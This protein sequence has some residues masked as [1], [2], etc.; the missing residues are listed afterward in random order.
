[1]HNILAKQQY[2]FKKGETFS[3]KNRLK[4]LKLLQKNIKNKDKKIA[5]ALYKDL[6]KS[7]NE[8][9]MCEIGLTINEISYFLKNLK[10]FT[11]DKI[12]PTPITNFYSKSII[13]SVPW[14]NV[15]IISPWNYPFLLS[16][17]PLIDAIAAGN[18]VI[19]KPSAY[20]P[21][22]KQYNKRAYRRDL[23]I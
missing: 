18:T 8:A 7:Y 14:G 6:G 22:Y 3:I 19:L 12:V 5:E 9:Y 15:L 20:S 4:Y 11:K 2:F 23:P 13:K 17:D 10:K 1:M 21:S 16:I